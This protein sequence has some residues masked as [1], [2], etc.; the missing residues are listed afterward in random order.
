MRLYFS[1]NFVY[2]HI[3]SISTLRAVYCK[4]WFM[5]QIVSMLAAFDTSLKFINFNEIKQLHVLVT[6]NSVSLDNTA[7]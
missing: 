5:F 6:Y 7:K 3:F 4:S 1:V 2:K